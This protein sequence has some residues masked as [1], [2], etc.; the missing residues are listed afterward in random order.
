MKAEP[1]DPRNYPG[2]WDIPAPKKQE[3]PK[4]G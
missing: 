2:H 4:K 1:Y 3:E